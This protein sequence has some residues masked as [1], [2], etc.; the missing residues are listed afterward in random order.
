MGDVYLAHEHASNRL[1]A[2]KYVRD[3]SDPVLMSRFELEFR[4]IANLNHPHAVR[5]LGHD[6]QRADPYFVMELMEGGSV[7]QHLRTAGPLAPTEAVALV[8]KV[9]LAVGALHE[10]RAHDNPNKGILHRDI[11]PANILLTAD[12]EPKLADFGLVKFL[13]ASAVQTRATDVLGTAQYMPPEQINGKN[14]ELGF[15]ADVYGLGATLYHLLTGRAPFAGETVAEIFHD[16]LTQPPVAP[17]VLCPGLHP[18]LCAVVLKALAKEPS[19][20]F[21]TVADFVAALDTYPEWKP[22]PP[23]PPP[24]PA[25]R[26]RA[27]VRRNRARVAVAAGATVAVAAALFL[28]PSDAETQLREKLRADK[29][30][31]V[32]P[33][34]GVPRGLERRW[35]FNAVP[36]VESPA[37]GGACSF[38]SLQP[39]LLAFLRDPGREDYDVRADF[40]VLRT[41][42]AIGPVLPQAAFFGGGAALFFGHADTRA[43]DGSEVHAFV[44]VNYD[45]CFPPNLVAQG[46]S[47]SLRVTGAAVV[48]RAGAVPELVFFEDLAPPM[49][50]PAVS[51]LPGDWR[52]ID[53]KVRRDGATVYW[54]TEP[55]ARPTLVANLSADQLTASFAEMQT[56]LNQKYPGL[57]VKLRDWSPR[58]AFGV[59]GN[60]SALAFKNVVVSP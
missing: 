28:V 23:P 57:N 29:T 45:E 49:K 7:A 13:D 1:V 6:F 2:L 3:P 58:G 36:L 43:A 21:Q 33:E 11:K 30:I 19:D 53:L 39:A 12:G 42:L 4:A 46:V 15:P 60:P 41:N 38:E 5:V 31:T 17:N 47:A 16:V 37:A 48:A 14:G 24:S 32:V 10:Q 35:L 50:F 59:H 8:R 25:E 55:A 54:R 27:W 26:F 40:L 56:Q 9:S 18:G 44:S 22:P 20:R 52:G 34:T 51:R